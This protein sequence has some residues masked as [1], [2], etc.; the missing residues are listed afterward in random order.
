MKF[1]PRFKQIVMIVVMLGWL[2]FAIRDLFYQRWIIGS[3]KF[4]VS[5]IFLIIFSDINNFKN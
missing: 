2:C 1:S 3:G 5:I 4:I